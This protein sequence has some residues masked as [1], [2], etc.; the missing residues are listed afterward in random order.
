MKLLLLPALLL[1]L[2]AV[3]AS[4]LVNLGLSTQNF[5]LKGIGNNSAGEGQSTVTF[6]TCNYDGTNTTCTVSGP[7]TGLGNG[8]TYSFVIVYAGNGAFP[9][10]A[11]SQSPGSNLFQYLAVGNLSS[12]TITLAE[13]GGPT[14]NFYSFANFTFLYSSPTCT[15]VAPSNCGVASVGAT[16][17]ATITGQITGSFDPAP[18]I[19]PNGAITAGN[20]GAFTSI[21]PGT[22]M[23]I[24]G[25]NLANVLSGNWQAGFVGNNAPTSVDG[26]SITVAGIPAYVA[27]VSPGQ[28]NIEVPSGVPS[29]TQQ[30]VVTTA[31]GTSTAY[32]IT[33]NATEPGMLAPPSFIINGQQNIVAVLSNTTTYI[34]PPGTIAGLTT[35]RTKPGDYITFYG[36][37]F[38]AVTPAMQA[39]TLVLA[40]NQI[41]ANFGVTMGGV[42]AT[43]TY[44]GLGPY[45]TGLYQFNVI[46][47]NIGAS[48]ATPVVFTLGGTPIP[49]NNL[50][51]AVN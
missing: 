7:F 1:S 28:V 42:P 8:G 25:V 35:V 44:D 45:Y 11:V 36:V 3:P 41:N 14:I 33:V 49:Q 18:S 22:W 43:V 5:A 4:A 32:N 24:Y 20:Y 27:Y 47:P 6:G 40:V 15:I 46:V 16:P 31:G 37:G 29:G 51:I 17:G 48:D 12:F 13:T 9:L 10:E 2:S 34:L 30:I 38:G 21:A 26:T 19:T 39:G 50:V 23:E